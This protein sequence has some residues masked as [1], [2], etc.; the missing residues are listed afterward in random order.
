MPFLCMLVRGCSWEEGG[1]MGENW[2]LARTFSK[3]VVLKVWS[4]PSSFSTAIWEQHFLSLIDIPQQEEGRFSPHPA[5]A[6][7]M[8]NHYNSAN[9]EPPQPLALAPLRVNFPSP[10]LLPAF[11]CI[12]Y[13]S[14]VFSRLA[15]SSL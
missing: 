10:Q 7:P 2:T 6:W 11:L 3:S 14:P 5:T 13:S 12:K 9:E 8:R 4:W 15:H 1:R